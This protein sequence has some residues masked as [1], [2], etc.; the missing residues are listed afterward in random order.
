MNNMNN[1]TKTIILHNTMKNIAIPNVEDVGVVIR[2]II[3]A[4]R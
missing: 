2:V 3:D 4:M 1:P